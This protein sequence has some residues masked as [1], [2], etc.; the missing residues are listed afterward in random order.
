MSSNQ[1]VCQLEAM[2]AA[3]S[4]ADDCQGVKTK[5]R[6]EQEEKLI[7]TAWKHMQRGPS[8]APAAPGPPR[9]FLAEQRQLTRDRRR[10]STLQESSEE[11]CREQNGSQD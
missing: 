9:S 5:W 1:Q 7:L 10:R 8:G 3:A 2:K 6:P 4:E 11:S